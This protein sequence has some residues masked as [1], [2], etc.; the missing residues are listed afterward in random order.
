[1]R[2]QLA[3]AVIVGLLSL[4][5]LL[6]VGMAELIPLAGPIITALPAILVTL[7]VSPPKPLL[8]AGLYLVIQQVENYL[9]VPKVMQRAMDLSTLTI[10]FAVLAG[11]TLGGIVGV[12]L[13][14]PI[15][16]SVILRHIVRVRQRL[17]G[18][19][20]PACTAAN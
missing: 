7:A 2:G 10:V 17:E 15:A 8:A 20:P 9:L 11:A 1:M 12:L 18:N 19:A 4:A 3:L 13:A 16:A 14:A 5:G 6:I